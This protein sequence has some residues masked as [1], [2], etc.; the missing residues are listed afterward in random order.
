M[1]INLGDAAGNRARAGATATILEVDAGFAE[2]G[3]FADISAKREGVVAIL[4]KNHT[5]AAEFFV[6][7]HRLLVVRGLF[8]VLQIGNKGIAFLLVEGRGVIA[9]GSHSK[10]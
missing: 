2:D 8:R 1:E 5:F 7:F 4:K 9:W 6:K 3:D 10:S